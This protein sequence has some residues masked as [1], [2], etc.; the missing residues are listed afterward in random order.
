MDFSVNS[1]KFMV[2]HRGL[3]WPRATLRVAGELADFLYLGRNFHCAV[4]GELAMSL[5]FQSWPRAAL[6]VAGKLAVGAV[7]SLALRVLKSGL[8][9]SGPAT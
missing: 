8:G 4:Q 7:L 6:R 3:C 2:W 1:D 5:L 9:L